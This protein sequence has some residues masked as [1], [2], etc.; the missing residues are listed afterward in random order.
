MPHRRRKKAMA[1]GLLHGN[2]K[3]KYTNLRSDAYRAKPQVTKIR[4]EKTPGGDLFTGYLGRSL[5]KGAA[6]NKVSIGRTGGKKQQDEGN[7]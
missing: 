3:G 4:K 7:L 1:M 6:N 5:E 2:G